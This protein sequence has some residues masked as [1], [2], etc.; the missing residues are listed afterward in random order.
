MKTQQA[1]LLSA[2]APL[3]LSL[4]Q[5]DRKRSAEEKFGRREAFAWRRDVVN[6][7][8]PNE[9]YVNS[10]WCQIEGLSFIEIFSEMTADGVLSR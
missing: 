8:P 3:R 5:Q 2:E 10:D 4:S 1:L 7:S 6:V 9:T